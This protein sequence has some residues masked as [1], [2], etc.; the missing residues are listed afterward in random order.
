MSLGLEV[1][2]DTRLWSV[3]WKLI[4]LRMVIA[5]SGLRRASLKRKIGTALLGVLFLAFLGFIFYL[6]WEL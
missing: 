1:R 5:V 3:V 4:K 6:S 2:P